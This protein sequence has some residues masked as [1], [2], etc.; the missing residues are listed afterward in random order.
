LKQRIINSRVGRALIA[1]RDNQLA[2]N[3]CGVNVQKYKIISFALSAFFTAY[4]GAMYAHLVTFISPESFQYAQSVL[5][6]TMLVFGGN[7]NLWGPVW[8][9]VVITLV[10]EG[11]Q[12]LQDYQMLIYGLF[13]LIAVTFLPQGLY[14]LVRK[15]ISHIGHKKGASQDA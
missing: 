14:G 11:L 15:L 6:L 12:S 9:A 13:L 7:G 2:A 8:G 5:F 4:A 10:Q 3:G 1:I